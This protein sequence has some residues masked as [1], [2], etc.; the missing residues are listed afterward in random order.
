MVRKSLLLVLIFVMANALQ[1]PSRTSQAA[2]SFKVSQEASADKT[3]DQTRK[4]IQILKGLP[5]SQLFL[6]MNFV[7]SSLGE[8]FTFCHVQEA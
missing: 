5:E 2:K 3:V 1:L 7:A 8:Q 6:L 4:N